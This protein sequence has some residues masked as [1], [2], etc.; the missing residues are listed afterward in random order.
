VTLSV[1][2]RHR[3]AGAEID[4][5]FSAPVPGLTILFGP[6]GAGKSTVVASIAGL[7]RP[8][9]CRIELN[10]NVLADTDTGVWTEPE[11]RGAGMVFQDARLF[12]HL[13]VGGNLQY[14]L[15]RAGAGPF[16]FDDIV[17]L[18]GIEEAGVEI[19]DPFGTD[20]ND[21]PLNAICETIRKN[22]LGG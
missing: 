17:G 5:G 10:G 16:A 21:L 20:E 18:L 1:D 15:R 3:F 22:V 13:S 7:L 19:E 6:S 14:G 11:R 12:P 4:I 2:L 8:E 9:M